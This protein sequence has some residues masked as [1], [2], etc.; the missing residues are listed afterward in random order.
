MRSGASRLLC[1]LVVLLAVVMFAVTLFFAGFSTKLST[2]RLRIVLLT[3]GWIV[4]IGTVAWLATF[5]I[6]ISV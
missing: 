3:A 5:P 6:S 2:S 4:F 1:V